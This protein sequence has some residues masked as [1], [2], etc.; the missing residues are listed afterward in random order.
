MEYF[1]AKTL[2]R[3]YFKVIS[4]PKIPLR[5]KPLATNPEPEIRNPKSLPRE[6]RSKFHWGEIRN[7][8][9]RTTNNEQQTTNNKPL[10][11]TIEVHQV[12]QSKL[13][14]YCDEYQNVVRK[15]GCSRLFVLTKLIVV[16]P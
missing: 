15:S 1:S 4:Q 8:K 11:A 13:A 5:A 9:Q 6:M 14:S 10:R 16:I 12:K 7:T 2:G 3:R